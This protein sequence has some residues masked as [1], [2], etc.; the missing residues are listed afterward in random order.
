MSALVTYQKYSAEILDYAIVWSFPDADTV[1]SAAWTI[2]DGD[3]DL[4]VATDPEHAASVAGSH[5]IVWLE[6]GTPGG[7]Y[8]ARCTMTTA[9]GRVLVRELAI[10]I[11]G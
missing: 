1:A 10:Q 11:V 7:R 4:T 9:L 2:P 6:G 3:G 5:T 8:A